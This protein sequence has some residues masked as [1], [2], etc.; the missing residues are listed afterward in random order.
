ML[1]LTAALLAGSLCLAVPQDARAGNIYDT[2]VLKRIKLDPGQRARVRKVLKRSDRELAVIF[3]K[4]GINP[5]AK[6]EFAKLRR[7]SSELQAV[8]TREKRKMKAIMSRDQYR[9]YL[10]LLQQT[11]ARIIKATRTR[12]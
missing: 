3:R 7:A 5:N 6:P 8:E 2:P 11:A 4:Y 1:T 9:A 10:D 12:P